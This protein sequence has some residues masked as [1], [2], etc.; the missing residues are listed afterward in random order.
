MPEELWIK[1]EILKCQ[2]PKQPFEWLQLTMLSSVVR[3]VIPAVTER[4]N[5]YVT[6]ELPLCER[7]TVTFCCHGNHAVNVNNAEDPTNSISSSLK[8]VIRWYIGSYA[9]QRRMAFVNHGG[10]SIYDD[11]Y[12]KT[13][14]I[15]LFLFQTWCREC[16][17]STPDN[18]V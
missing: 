15:C 4:I 13:R 18:P 6:T 8:K 17:I 10:I 7:I 5:I 2:I 3:V 11:K 9:I 1:R 16:I 14:P 12:L